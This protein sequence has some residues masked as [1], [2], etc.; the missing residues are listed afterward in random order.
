MKQI[1]LTDENFEV[2]KVCVGFCIDDLAETDGDLLAQGSPHIV[3]MP[4]VQGL[5]SA[6]EFCTR[7]VEA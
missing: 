2:L 4:E 3:R 6:I 7:D 1:T 5:R